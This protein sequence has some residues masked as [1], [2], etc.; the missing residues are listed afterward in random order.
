M[1]LAPK[2][3]TKRNRSFPTPSLDLAGGRLAFVSEFVSFHV[4]LRSAF[5]RYEIKDFFAVAAATLLVFP[6]LYGMRATFWAPNFNG[7]HLI[8]ISASMKGLY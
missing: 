1:T 8:H 3:Q 2:K 5:G 6:L 4:E 7:R